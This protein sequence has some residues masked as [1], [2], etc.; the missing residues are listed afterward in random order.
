MMMPLVL[1]LV[2]GT[3]MQIA[4]AQQPCSTASD[5][6]V[7]PQY[8]AACV[9]S[10]CQYTCGT[11]LGEGC[12]PEWT[13]FVTDFQRNVIAID[14]PINWVTRIAGHNAT[15]SYAYGASLD[16]NQ[17]LTVSAQ[18]TAGARVLAIDVHVL[19][20]DL[21]LCHNDLCIEHRERYSDI[22][23]E[24]GD[25]LD[26]NPDEFIW[27]TLEYLPYQSCEFLPDGECQDGSMTFEQILYALEDGVRDG[28]PPTT[29][30]RGKTRW[31]ATN[32]PTR[33]S[34]PTTA[35][36]RATPAITTIRSVRRAKPA[37][38]HIRRRRISSRSGAGQPCANCAAKA[39]R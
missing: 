8:E 20:G 32:T 31:G 23:E 17:S 34:R 26:A 9:L 14:E 4:S 1:A 15:E 36:P 2:C 38:W 24:I 30:W 18:L 21:W 39:S 29:F 33:S 37:N 7:F 19:D 27:I 28:G 13:R 6:Q 5:C 25:W 22:M 16:P 35:A 10:Q 12:G 3:A 11:N